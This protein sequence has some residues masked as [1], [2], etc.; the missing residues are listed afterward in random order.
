M[1]NKRIIIL[2]L[3]ISEVIILAGSAATP[4]ISEITNPDKM[5]GKAPVIPGDNPHSEN[6]NEMS[7][8]MCIY[9]KTLISSINL[10]LILPLIMIYA[11]IYRKVKSSFTLGLIAVIFAQ[12]M[13]AITSNPT[14]ITIFG[15]VPGYIGIYQIIPDI[16]TAAALIVL[17]RISLE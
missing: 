12:G 4:I 6:M 2:I 7:D 10:G 16:C 8:E 5:D 15:G 14:I 9:L 1:K 11:G 17:I 13:Y 3:L